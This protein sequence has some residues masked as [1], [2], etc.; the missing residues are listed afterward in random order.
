MCQIYSGLWKWCSINSFT[1][2]IMIKVWRSRFVGSCTLSFKRS[3][4]GSRNVCLLLL[5]LC[6]S[7]LKCKEP[8]SFI[9]IAIFVYVNIAFIS[10]FHFSRA[11][12]TLICSIWLWLIRSL[13]VLFLVPLGAILP[14]FGARWCYRFLNI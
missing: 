9:C 4:V 3:I 6:K 14:F 11:F 13:N 7:S 5:S 2:F 10:E 1:D 8:M 12:I